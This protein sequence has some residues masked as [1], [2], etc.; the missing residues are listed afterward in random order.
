MS[1]R[2]IKTYLIIADVEILAQK[3]ENCDETKIGNYD[4]LDIFI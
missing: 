3:S 2:N 1:V 4:E